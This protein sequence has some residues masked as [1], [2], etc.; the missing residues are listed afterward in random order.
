MKATLLYV[1]ALLAA[2][3]LGACSENYLDTESN[4]AEKRLI[5]SNTSNIAMAVNG[6]SKMM[7]TQYLKTQ[8]MNGEGTI[9]TQYGNLHGNDFQKCDF[10]LWLQ[11]TNLDFVENS[12]SIYDYYPWYY[13]YKILGN[14]NAIISNVDAA[15]GPDNEKRFLKAQAL[16]FRAYCFFRLSQ[17]YSKRWAD[18]N[19]GASRGVVLR[20]D[21]ST[22][23]MAISTLAETYARIYQDLD[24]ALALYAES[25]LNRDGD[26]NYAVNADVAHAIYARAAL[27]REDWAT[28]ASHAASARANYTLMNN[29]Q[30]VDGGFN[31]PNKEWIWSV[32]SNAQETLHYFQF[33][34]F[35]GSNSNAAAARNY[36]C[37]I[38]KELYDS[39]PTTDVRRA[40]FLNPD[41]MTFNTS[42]GLAG[43]WMTA[44]AKR[45]YKKKLYSTSRIYAYMQFKMQAVSNPG[46]G[47]IPLF[48]AAEMYL[49]EAEANCHLGKEA[50]AQALLVALNKTSGRDTAYTC[51]K[52]GDELLAEVRRYRR[53]ELWGEGFDWFDYKRWN[54][55][56]VRRTFA[57]GGSFH[58]AFAV[59]IKPN[60]KNN[61]TWVIPSR[62]T[63][64]NKL[65]TSNKE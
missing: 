28:A 35:Q 62:E 45:V 27:T 49:T 56:I 30:Y 17:L 63:D 21:E 42:S 61:W 59:T 14:A 20:L 55:P 52:T 24:D 40:M 3:T 31:A 65:I 16:T 8:G 60:E 18:S 38:S 36:P 53:I 13:Y 41:T 32:Y 58:S 2:L 10:T 46:V 57:D 51:T 29:A 19:N 25:K 54:L 37:A 7:S 50:E 15:T 43:K 33:F 9:L 5:L 1:Y 12:T 6:L 64:Y 39:I 34:A 4:N 47:E 11:M 48:R 23:N 22:G 26:E 44:Y